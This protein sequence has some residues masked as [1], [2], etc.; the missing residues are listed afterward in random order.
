MIILFQY[1]TILPFNLERQLITL[2]SA[3]SSLL[4]YRFLL[5]QQS[6]LLGD[7][8]MIP[9]LLVVSTYNPKCSRTSL[10]CSSTLK[11]VVLLMVLI[12]F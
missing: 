1:S 12:P 11:L 4:N 9:T 8:H 3:F 6:R 10:N 7:L 2:T 5:A